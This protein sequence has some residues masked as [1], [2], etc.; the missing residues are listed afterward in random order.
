MKITINTKEDS[1]DDIKKVIRLLSHLVGEESK[2]ATNQVDIFKD[3][4]SADENSGGGSIFGNMFDSDPAVGQNRQD[5][6]KE[7]KDPEIIPY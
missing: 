6:D 2:P 5:E 4:N 3:Q 1:H 7:K